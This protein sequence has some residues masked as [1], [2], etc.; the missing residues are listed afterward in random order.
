MGSNIQNVISLL[1]LHHPKLCNSVANHNLFEL[2]LVP[3]TGAKLKKKPIKSKNKDLKRAASAPL[4]DY[5]VYNHN[6]INKNDSDIPQ[7]PTSPLSISPLNSN[8]DDIY[9]KKSTEYANEADVRE[10]LRRLQE[11]YTQLV[12]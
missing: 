5:D 8:R 7:S 6:N 4:K 1:K 3:N 12:L 2:N 11:E 9:N 10:L